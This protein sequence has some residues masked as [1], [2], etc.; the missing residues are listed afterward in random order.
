MKNKTLR[1]LIALARLSI[2]HHCGEARSI[3][4][5]RSATIDLAINEVERWELVTIQQGRHGSRHWQIVD[6]GGF[7]NVAAYNKV[8]FKTIKQAKEWAIDNAN[9]SM[10]L[11]D[12][13]DL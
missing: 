5:I 10:I 8:T 6:C 3:A 12:L 4:N 11:S 2:T 13:Y 7:M 9:E 1:K